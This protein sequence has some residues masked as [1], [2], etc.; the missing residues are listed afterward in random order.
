LK[1]GEEEEEDV[2]SYWRTLRKGEDTGNFKE[3]ALDRAMGRTRFGRGS[4]PVV[5]QTMHWM[6]YITNKAVDRITQPGGRR[7]RHHWL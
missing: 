4:G 3:E 6:T 5:R 2:S 7:A 1:G